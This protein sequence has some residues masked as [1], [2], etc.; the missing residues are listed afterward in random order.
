MEQFN[1]KKEIISGLEEKILALTAKNYLKAEIVESEEAITFISHHITQVKCLLSTSVFTQPSQ[2]GVIAPH[3][4][5][6]TPPLQVR[7]R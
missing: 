6:H 2:K 3:S 4:K 7:I 1:R 5:D